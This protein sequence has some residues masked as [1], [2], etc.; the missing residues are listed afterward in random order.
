M[1]FYLSRKDPVNESMNKSAGLKLP[2]Q[3]MPF[4]L[5]Q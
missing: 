1:I 5:S 3:V 4:R 2:R